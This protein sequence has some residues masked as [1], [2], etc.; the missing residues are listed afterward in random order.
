M[1]SA[2]LPATLDRTSSLCKGRL[3]SHI[4]QFPQTLVLSAVLLVDCEE[5]LYGL[6][7][8]LPCVRLAI[9]CI[10]FSLEQSQVL[11]VMVAELFLDSV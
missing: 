8:S 6:V 9:S 5:W 7:E 4:I 3:H 11:D 1:L 2:S 10:L